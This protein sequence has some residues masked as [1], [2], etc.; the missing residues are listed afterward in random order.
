MQLADLAPVYPSPLRLF[1]RASW[2]SAC[3]ALLALAVACQREQPGPPEAP[4]QVIVGR[5]SV[6]VAEQSRIELGPT[7]SGALEPKQRSVIVAEAAGSVEAAPVELGDAVRRGQLLARIEADALENASQSAEASVQARKQSLELAERQ[8][9]R[10]EELVQA[11]ALAQNE[12]EVARN[13]VAIQRAELARAEAALASARTQ[14]AGAVVRSPIDGVISQKAVHQGD[15]VAP[16]SPL[17]TIIDPSSMRLSASVPS[18]SLAVL[19]VGAPVEFRVRGLGEQTF[20]GHIERIGPAADPVTRQIPILV[21]LPNTSGKLIAGLFADGRVAAQQKTALVIPTAALNQTG[22]TLSVR[23]L[24]GDRVEVVPVS[25]GIE[26]PS[27]ERVEITSGLAPGDRV[28][29]G[30]ARELPPGTMVRVE[31]PAS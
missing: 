11:G 22:P 26:D 23:R 9:R 30:A 5:E 2:P 10:V 4:P 24:E 31:G 15:V 12:L 3:A 21:S 16:G 14:L 20:T 17:Y 25:I 19:R 27:R 7:L 13:D 28:L 18:E 6:A 8:A 1:R 29:L